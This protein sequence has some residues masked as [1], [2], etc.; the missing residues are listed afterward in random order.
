VK[1]CAAA[2]VLALVAAAA[3]AAPSPEMSLA[4]QALRSGRA[5]DAEL[6]FIA[7]EAAAADT[8]A[9]L[10]VQAERCVLLSPADTAAPPCAALGAA[11]A[12]AG[13]PPRTRFLA[14]E[15]L[16]TQAQAQGRADE[17]LSHRLAAL[18]AAEAVGAPDPRWAA[19]GALAEQLRSRGQPAAAAYFGKQALAAIEALRADVSAQAAAAERGFLYDRLEVHRQLAAGLAADGR[20]A[21]ALQVLALLKEE[22][23]L[24]FVQR[25][26]AWIDNGLQAP[27]GE[28]E[29]RM[30]A[31]W[32]DLGSAVPASGGGIPLA[33][34]LLRSG[35]N[36]ADDAAW[37]DRAR[38]ALRDF[39][40]LAPPAPAPAA[41]IPRVLS[42]QPVAADPV[43]RVYA[44]AGETHLTLIFE[45]A[46]WAQGQSIAWPRRSLERDIGAALSALGRD[47][48]ARPRLQDLYQRLG[49]P[50]AEAARSRGAQQ[51]V[52]IGDGVLRYLPMAALHDG[53]GWLGERFVLSQQA[54]PLGPI[55]RGLATPVPQLL[56]MGVSRGARPLPGVAR[57]VCAIVAGPVHGLG[58]AEPACT[59]AGAVPGEGWLNEQ[60]TQAR[61]VRATATAAA[62]VGGGG[63]LHVGTHFD[64]RPGQMSRSSLLL[65]D[66][67]RL[68]LDSLA[69]MDFQGQ[70]LVTLSACETAAGGAEDADGREIEG[71]NLLFVRR[72]ARAVLASLWRVEDDSTSVLMATFY[73]ELPRVGPAL[74]LQRAQAEVRSRPG[75]ASPFH[76]AGFFLTV[77]P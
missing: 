42:R 75:W 11:L 37:V 16:A 33:R 43:L 15:A 67:Q 4:L 46:S 35:R 12:A 73:R 17:A 72:G 68:G 69:Q 6:A 39:E 62:R 38:S 14:H 76:W 27:L 70:D 5:A 18:A 52:L 61:L 56:A 53:Q 13:L 63:M 57:E 22:E 30:D 29:R 7:A 58:L 51:V 8:P 3:A 1:G 36:G 54:R 32:Q 9:R 20:I 41:P 2:C 55:A 74:A 45:T 48:D 34:D 64:L 49:R 60:F 21:E 44:V 59:G 28:A 47:E 40:G 23:F 77:R 50:I 10:A 24:D 65:G 25:D 26:R 31:R 19:L 66:G 71:L